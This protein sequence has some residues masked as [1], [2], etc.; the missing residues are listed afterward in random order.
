MMNPCRKTRCPQDESLQEDRGLLCL[1]L[2]R[3]KKILKRSVDKER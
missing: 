3:I 2:C 1:M